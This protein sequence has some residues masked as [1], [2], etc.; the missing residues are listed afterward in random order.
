MP[1]ENQKANIGVPDILIKSDEKR[2]FSSSPALSV[3]CASFNLGKFLKET[4]NSIANQ[5]SNRFECIVVD[6]A[7]RDNSVEILKQYPNIRWIS[8]K[9]SGYPEA[10][11]KG[12]KMARGRYIIQCAVSDAFANEEWVDKCIDTLDKNPDVSLV[13]GFPQRLSEASIPGNVSYPQFHHTSVP[14]RGDFFSYWLK[15]SFFFPEGNLCVRKDVV[16]ECYP[17]L[18]SMDKDE[19]DWLEFNHNFHTRG[20]LSLHIPVVANFGR[21]HDGQ[22]GENLSKS[23]MIYRMHKRYLRKVRKYRLKVIFGLMTP[24]FRDHQKRPLPT[25]F[26][27][28]AFI[29]E[30]IPYALRQSIL[31]KKRYLDPRRY[32]A[33]L[34]RTIK[35]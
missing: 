9:D 14:A 28:I 27:K 12:L 19:L 33:F 21:T 10:F 25:E 7:S 5:H 8:E 34:K 3:I 22:M 24:S 16:D 31:S 11:R 30:Y 1:T 17:R 23:K 35:K 6:G 18:E 15:T 13:W 4:L 29:K 20:Y 2:E 26:G 32:I